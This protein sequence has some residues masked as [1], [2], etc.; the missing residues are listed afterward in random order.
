MSVMLQVTNCIKSPRYERVVVFFER[1]LEITYITDTNEE[2]H[3]IETQLNQNSFFKTLPKQTGWVGFKVTKFIGVL[4]T[5]LAVSIS[6]LMI[7]VLRI[8]REIFTFPER[9]YG[10]YRLGAIIA[11]VL[12]IILIVGTV[13]VLFAVDSSKIILLVTCVMLSIVAILLFLSFG[14]QRKQAKKQREQF[15]RE[16]VTTTKRQVIW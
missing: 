6:Y 11:V 8:Y 10:C 1:P 5:K 14:W 2:T 16:W 3:K 12:I 13:P 4:G 7:S 9:H 15:G